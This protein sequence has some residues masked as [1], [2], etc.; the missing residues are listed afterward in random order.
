MEQEGQES[1]E[2]G[3]STHDREQGLQGRHGAGWSRD[4]AFYGGAGSGVEQ[5]ASVSKDVFT[6]LNSHK[7]LRV[8]EL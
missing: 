6:L 3:E 8:Y 2:Q 4:G 1:R 5:G 7:A